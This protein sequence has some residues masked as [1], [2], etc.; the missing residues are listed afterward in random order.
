M[1]IMVRLSQAYRMYL[2]IQELLIQKV[3]TTGEP[4]PLGLYLR[5]GLQF[6]EE[7]AQQNAPGQEVLFSDHFGP[8]R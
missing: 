3:L 6:R 4:L 7:V 2:N 5:E 8:P 1:L